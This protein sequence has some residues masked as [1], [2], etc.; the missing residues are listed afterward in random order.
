MCDRKNL[1]SFNEKERKKKEGIVGVKTNKNEKKRLKFYKRQN[2][3]ENGHIGKMKR[4]TGRFVRYRE[5]SRALVQRIEI[6]GESVRG[7]GLT[8]V[9]AEW[10][11][12]KPLCMGQNPYQTGESS[13]HTAIKTRVVANHHVPLASNTYQFQGS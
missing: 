7:I 13:A 6:L 8:F 2:G 9:K 11:T 10:V 4:N 12:G 1:S 5:E 3:E